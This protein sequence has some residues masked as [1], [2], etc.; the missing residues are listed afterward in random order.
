MLGQMLSL[1]LS[2]DV[3]TVTKVRHPP[4]ATTTHPESIMAW[5]L[6]MSLA[7]SPPCRSCRPLITCLP[8][9]LSSGVGAVDQS[10]VGPRPVRQQP[11]GAAAGGGRGRRRHLA[12]QGRA[13]EVRQFD[14]LASSFQH[15]ALSLT[16]RRSAAAH[17]YVWCSCASLV[18]WPVLSQAL[19][20]GYAR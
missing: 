13:Q 5:P 12:R 14:V 15:P 9:Y 6:C 8:A 11:A 19:D 3:A 16:P 2:P 1:D 4:L 7:S 18:T 17:V 20:R 10:E